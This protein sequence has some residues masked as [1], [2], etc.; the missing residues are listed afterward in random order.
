MAKI[1]KLTKAGETIYPATTADAVVHPE[2]KVAVSKLVDEVNVSK[3]YP[4]GGT[5]G[6]DRYTLETA[7]AKIPAGV[8]T[9]GI[10]CSFID[11]AGT[12]QTWQYTGGAFTDRKC[13]LRADGTTIN[14]CVPMQHGNIYIQEM[15][16]EG[17]TS[18]TPEHTYVISRIARNHPT[19]GYAVYFKDVDTSKEFYWA[20]NFSYKEGDFI[21]A[22]LIYS[23]SV[24]LRAIINWDKI[25]MGEYLTGLDLPLTGIFDL[26][27]NAYISS[28][29]NGEAFLEI[30]ERLSFV[31]GKID[32]SNTS[33]S[34]TFNT[35]LSSVVGCNFT[36]NIKGN[37]DV[38][39]IEVISGS[40]HI[41]P[42]SFSPMINGEYYY[43]K[44]VYVSDY[45]SYINVDVENLTSF[46]V[47]IGIV[48]QVSVGSV[49]MQAAFSVHGIKEDISELESKTTELESK[50]T[51]LDD[52][53]SVLEQETDTPVVTD[54]DFNPSIHINDNIYAV[55]GDTLQL[56]YDSF[57]HHIAP[58]SLNL[59]CSKGKNYVRYWEY[60][61]TP[62]DVG[63]TDMTI[64][65]LDIKGKIIEGKSI[66]LITKEAKDPASPTNVLFV[67]DSLMMSGQQPIE[68]SRRL[69]GTAGVAT[70]PVA[71]PLTNFNIKGRKVNADMTVGWEGT[72][73]WSWGS[74]YSSNGNAGIRFTVSD[75]SDVRPGSH[76]TIDG[77][78]QRVEISEINTTLQ[79]VFGIFYGQGDIYKDHGLLPQS[80]TLS[81]GDGGGQETITFTAASIETYQ[82]FWNSETEQFDIKNYVDKYC[83]GHVE[84]ICFLLGTN[85]V[86][87]L[88]PYTGDIEGVVN[89]AKT[90]MRKIHEQLPDTTI[91][92]GTEPL[93]SQNGGLGK[94]YSAASKADSYSAISF[95]YKI[96]KLDDA[97][98]T[99]EIDNEFSSY[100][101][102]V[103][104]CAQTDADYMFPYQEVNI[105]TRMSDFKERRDT[106]AV[107]FRNE[108]HWLAADAWFRALICMNTDTD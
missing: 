54:F 2:L 68:V 90:L 10:K 43:T 89:S 49:V 94:S 97:Y 96:H 77:F 5:D 6:T 13:W 57:V 42:K 98:R 50:T 24:H 18:L 103:D 75:L 102:V 44:Q 108:G 46:S 20:F 25:P 21:D 73:G 31:N 101:K 7:I 9:V 78:T 85:S 14:E 51:E 55:V 22:T 16:V 52:R 76:Y 106:D 64:Q 87:S 53:M 19:Y 61:P 86:I 81:L 39:T 35:N 60:T 27:R 34:K 47:N 37:E 88:D 32:G 56:F 63:T 45:K 92:V 12:P 82:P 66:N 28:V 93:K 58:Y 23:E 17:G 69:K 11:D 100:V 48:N 83:D 30:D 79:T 71:L 33:V 26:S 95:N 1:N 104:L 84:Y 70:A 38:I 107:H 40:E 59:L 29:I 36:E 74:Y 67:G 65:L 91:L 3:V 15:Y 8:R 105:N 4:K 41:K 62:S 80:G 72:G 99:L